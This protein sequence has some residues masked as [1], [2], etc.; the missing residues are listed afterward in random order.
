MRVTIVDN[1]DSFTYNLFD[2]IF[3]VSGMAAIPIG[4]EQPGIAA[5]IAHH[6]TGDILL[7]EDEL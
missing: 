7:L 6:G 4:Y 1:Y 5:R 2:I 3:R